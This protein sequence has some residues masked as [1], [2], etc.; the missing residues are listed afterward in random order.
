MIDRLEQLRKLESN[1]D[2]YGAKNLPDEVI[3]KAEA[4]ARQ[5]KHRMEIFPT[6][7]E[8]VQ[9]EYTKPDTGDYIEIEVY[10]NKIGVLEVPGKVDYAKRQYELANE[11]DLKDDTLLNI[12]IDNF[13]EGTSLICEVKEK[14]RVKSRRNEY[15]IIVLNQSYTGMKYDFVLIDG[16]RHEFETV[17]GI[18][19]EVNWQIMVDMLVPN[20]L[21]IVEF[22]KEV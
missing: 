9:F 15:S 5:M 4:I 20:S 3:D 8:T 19:N 22:L 12:I 2:G 17:T 18:R 6:G 13:F 10:K 14:Y 7:R 11:Y 21:K 16:E 1:W